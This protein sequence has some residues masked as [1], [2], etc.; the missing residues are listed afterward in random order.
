MSTIKDVARLAG[1]SLGTVSNVLN[2]KTNNEELIAKVEKAVAELS[3]RPDAMARGLKSTRVHL[4]GVILPDAWQSQYQE[5]LMTLEKYFRSAG[6]SLVVRFSRNNQLIEKQS[7]EAFLDIRVS[8]IIIYSGSFFQFRDEWKKDPTP[9]LLISTQKPNSFYGDFFYLDYAPGFQE[10][11]KHLKHAR[12][13]H[14]GLVMERSFFEKSE[15][16][17]IYDDYFLDDSLVVLT[18]SAKETGFRAAFE[19]FS[20]SEYIDAIIAGSADLGEGLKKGLSLLKKDALP[21][22]AVKA[23]SWIQ[24]AYLYE[25]EISISLH[26]V[27]VRAV[28]VLLDKI[29]DPSASKDSITTFTGEFKKVEASSPAILP[30]SSELRFAM[31]DCSSA[32]SLQMYSMIYERESGQKIRFDM[33]PYKELET[34]L[35]ERADRKDSSYDGFMI[36]IAWFH[37]LV[38]SGSVKNLDH[39]LKNNPEY[40]QDFTKDAV[41]DYGMYVESLFAIP[42]MSGAQLLY[43]QRDLFDNPDLQRKY[44]RKYNEPLAP[45]ET[46]K[47]FNAIAE[48][49]TKSF[50]PD[51]PVKYGIS[52]SYGNN[53]YLTIDFLTRLWSYGGDL[54]DPRGN[55]TINSSNALDALESLTR[56]YTYCSGRMLDSWDRVAREF[57]Q[58]NSAMTI[59][60]NSDAGE[61]ND[62]T[63]SRVAGNLGYSLIPGK[64]AVQGGWSLALNRYGRNQKEAERFLLWACDKSN[65]IPLTLMG[66]STLRKDY[67]QSQD[68]EKIQPWK[69]LTE[70]TF[71]LSRKRIMPEI[72]DDS[73]L[74]NRI[75]TNIVPGEILEVLNHN[76]K[77]EEALKNMEKQISDLIRGI[78]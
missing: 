78:E 36:D 37:A 22:Y 31:Y 6:Y 16:S 1:V 59:L 47:Q 23:S 27:A 67:Y 68:I 12:L 34:T 41:K 9:M 45:P 11:L 72:L 75:Y 76:I 20:K 52:M 61:I 19:L 42:F 65:G 56:S 51:S 5:L 43:Y 2:G 60:Y 48:F 49:F 63:H 39:I 15:I 70:Q 8:A 3:Y 35:Y 38:E 24:D 29:D 73:R 10:A 14:V 18:D 69:R 28:S 46:W 21:V 13:D 50:T 32:R 44:Q 33:Y 25:G 55:I 30:S 54:F 64:I 66:G 7:I 77:M 62:P 74:K 26:D 57:A 71:S 17:R 53:V 4:I 58:G 40:L